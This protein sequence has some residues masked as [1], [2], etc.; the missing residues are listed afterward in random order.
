[1]TQRQIDS[2]KAVYK[3]D[4]EQLSTNLLKREVSISINDD[5][6]VIVKK[7]GRHL[8]YQT[9][10]HLVVKGKKIKIGKEVWEKLCNLQ[11]S[12]LFLHSFIEEH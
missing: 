6:Q 9:F 12:I 5:I 4:I 7:A 1:M 2:F 3:C 8:Q 11:E 10:I